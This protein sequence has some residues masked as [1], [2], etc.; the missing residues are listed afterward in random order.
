MS[1]NNAK[2]DID[3]SSDGISY[4]DKSVCNFITSE[5]IIDGKSNLSQSN[6]LG[7]HPH[8]LEKIKQSNGYRIPL[9]TLGIICFYKKVSLSE[10]FRMVEKKY[11]AKINEN[12]ALK[13]K[14]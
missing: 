12:F 4:L 8:T 13:S 5:W 7:I 6:D 2:N 1:K 10:F 14:K 3:K 9:T 11:G